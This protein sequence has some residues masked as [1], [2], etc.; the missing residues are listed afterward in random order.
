MQVRKESLI[1]L[2][3][4]LLALRNPLI[5][6]SIFIY[7]VIKK[8][9]A[10]RFIAGLAPYAIFLLTFFL[11][12]LTKNNELPFIIGQTRDILLAA[13]VFI[14]LLTSSKLNL[15]NKIIVYNSLKRVFVTIGAAKILIILFSILTGI[16][17]GV[18][19]GWIRD[20]WNI[21]MMTLN[22]TDST[23][24]RLQIPMDSALPV[25]LYAAF[26]EFSSKNKKR[27]LDYIVLFL[28]MT[29]VILTL[30]RALWAFMTLVL[31][32]FFILETKVIL[33]LKLFFIAL[34]II[35][36]SMFLTPLGG[37]IIGIL[38]SRIENDRINSA[39]DSLRTYQ[40]NGLINE[41]VKE[42]ILGHGL[43]HYLPN[44]LRSDTVKYLYESQT[45][46]MFMDVGVLGV[47]ILVMI[48]LWSIFSQYL[49]R[50]V[51]TKRIVL[52]VIFFMIWVVSGSYNP[53]LFG[54]SGGTMLFLSAM[55]D[56][57]YQRREV[58]IE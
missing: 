49:G 11:Y 40:N 44:L 54:V 34:I 56:N 22:V 31:L 43:G 57:F 29:S 2:S 46:S 37:V 55:S 17:S 5:I 12:S 50:R 23:I 39:S 28:L 45:L 8:G 24:F 42:P 19:I 35:P 21:Q 10:V 47:F 3:I 33:K 6:L 20:T 51:S 13:I 9:V 30:S 36:C 1:K 38:N 48:L 52:S 14:F 16:N 4:Y 15:D 18:I 7:I 27:A 53:Y 41:F 25:F 32:L 58:K 26:K